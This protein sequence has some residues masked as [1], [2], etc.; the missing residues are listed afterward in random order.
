MYFKKRAVGKVPAEVKTSDIIIGYRAN[1][2][3]FSLANAFLNNTL[4]LTQ[5]EKALY[6]GILGEQTVLKSRKS[7]EHIR[8]VRSESAERDIFYPMKI[9]RDR[10][11][12]PAYLRERGHQRASDSVYL[13]DILRGGW[14]SDD[15]RI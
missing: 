3:Y 8:Y 6:L 4:S 7:F 10:E 11:A 9:A 12:R 13:M 2:S 5:L 1:D 15:T 14:D